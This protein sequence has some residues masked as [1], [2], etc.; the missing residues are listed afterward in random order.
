MPRLT[1][2]FLISLAIA[3]AAPTAASAAATVSIAGKSFGPAAVTVAP[4][5]AVTWNWGSGPHNVHV[6]SGP[7]TFDSG[8]KDTGGTYTRTLTA[9][10]TYTYQCD[11]HPTMHGTV[12]VGGP[13]AAG[14]AG[15]AAAPA[16]R[17]VTVSRLAVVRLSSTSAGRLSIRL[18]RNGRV[19]R[20][21]TT[22]LAAGA[23]RV[24]L[25]VHGLPR[26]RYRVQL[27][28]TTGAGQRSAT[29][30][31]SLLVTRAVLARRIAATPAPVPAAPATP[32]ADDHGGQHHSDHAAPA[33][34]V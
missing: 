23:N 4:G 19:A 31:R 8:I 3:A 28:A 15:V 25:S 30:V 32:P 29:V 2:A 20:R 7:E 10:G 33:P 13:A 21:A 27:Q 22:T 18:L 9:P 6:T 34:A 14:P 5:D 12:V 26:G 17:T 24:P 16:L 1:C 11:V